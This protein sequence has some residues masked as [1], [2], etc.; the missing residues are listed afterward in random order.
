MPA[1]NLCQICM[2]KGAS[3]KKC[4]SDLKKLRFKLSTSKDCSLVRLPPCESSFLQHVLRSILQTKIWMTAD[5]AKPVIGSPL[6]YA[7]QEGKLGLEPILFVGHMSSDFLQ[8][9]I[10]TCKCKS[11]CSTACVC[12]EQ[13]LACT[14]L[15]PC[16]AKEQCFNI[17]SRRTETV[18]GDDS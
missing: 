9:L 3:K 12:F 10:C 7:W 4:H 16:Q 1:G 13:N 11:V 18:E 5:Q 6:S 17:H 15:C 14:D 2:T 8:D